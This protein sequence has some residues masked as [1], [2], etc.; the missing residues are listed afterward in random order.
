MGMFGVPQTILVAPGPFA[1]MFSAA[2]VADAIALGLRDGGRE[3]DLCP[4]AD[5][6][7]GT[8]ELLDAVGFDARMRA[9]RCVI[10]GERRLDARSLVGTLVSEVATRARQGGV[11]CHVVCSVR[12]LDAMGARVLDLE[13]VREATT[14]ARLRA[15]GR[16]LAAVI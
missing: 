9:S 7:E 1:G 15:A 6:G 12:A 3:V 16:E 11:P 2:Q 10:T 13:R 5:G 14:P 8:L 4:L